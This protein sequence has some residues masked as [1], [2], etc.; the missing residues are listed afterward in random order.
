[1]SIIPAS[2]TFDQRTLSLLLAHDPV[3][4]RYRVFFA[5]FDWRVV[6]E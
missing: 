4:Q 6:P 2:Q 1:M 5:L 3:V